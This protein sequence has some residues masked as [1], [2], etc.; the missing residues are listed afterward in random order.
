MEN[1]NEIKQSVNILDVISKYVDLK[2]HRGSEHTGLCPFHEEKTPSFGV[3]EQKQIFKCFGCGE[4]GD[5]FDFLMKQGRTFPEAIIELKGGNSLSPS[6]DFVKKPAIKPAIT[7]NQIIPASEP[8]SFEHYK[9]GTPEE[10]YTYRNS[11]G[12]TLGYI[13]RFNLQPRKECLPYIFASDGNRSLWR[14]QGFANPRPL[15]NLDKITNYPN[16]TII[17]CE[18]EKTADAIQ[19]A[20]GENLIVTTWIG[21][22]NAVKSTNF[23]ILNGRKILLWPDNDMVGHKAITE[24]YELLNLTNDVKFINNDDGLPKGWDAADKDWKPKEIMQYINSH[25]SI[26]FEDLDFSEKGVFPIEIFPIE[27]QDLINNFNDTLNYSKDYMAIAMLFSFS[28][29]NGNK[30]KFK[31]KNTWVAPSI[32]WFAAVG[33]SGVMKTHP[34]KTIIEHIKSIDFDS[35]KIYDCEFDEWENLSDTEKKRTKKPKFKQTLVYDFT[36]ES[37]HSIHSINK[38]GLGLYKDELISFLKDL[39][40]YRK[41]SDEEF[42]LESFNN[43]SYTVNRVSKEPVIV[44]DISINIIGT[45]Q[46]TVLE[47]LYSAN[48]GNGMLE[49]FLYTMNES[50][51]YPMSAIDADVEYLDWWGKI[52][53]RV[54]IESI[55]SN[56]DD[57]IILNCTPEIFSLFC[58]Y[59]KKLIQIQEEQNTTALIVGYCNK[60]KTYLPRFAL[61][62]CLMDY[63][64]GDSPLEISALHA[65]KAWLLVQY[66]LNSAEIL[67]NKLNKTAELKQINN[68]LNGLS[69]REKVLKLFSQGYKQS[70]IAKE[71]KITKGLVSRYVNESK[72]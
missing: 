29:L 25:T 45:I 63:Y 4:T 72:R 10:I 31:Y 55:Y 33:D 7:W 43:G 48:A 59:D 57:T 1:I 21:G 26:S 42:Y 5:V 61:V 13:C 27:M 9:H 71:L 54:N 11:D 44:S 56:K 69:N 16:K 64:N 15:Y 49:R 66:F 14:W 36:L 37:I 53:N 19:L 3:N 70:D 22:T 67:F 30:I 38:R 28:T 50:K 68:K 6:N 34:L 20:I 23:E 18:G 12:S 65:Q 52:L 47:T 41:G 17:I 46:P 39:N 32:F 2:H 62:C 51:I 60:M 40:K 24:I 35:K 8:E 58:E